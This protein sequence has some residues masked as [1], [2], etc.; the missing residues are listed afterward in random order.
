M[1]AEP[2]AVIALDEL[3]ARMP[4]LNRETGEDGCA[5]EPP[6]PDPMGEGGA[7]CPPTMSG[8]EGAP[9]KNGVGDA[10]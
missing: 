6:P 8:D 4:L 7:W 5:Y 3:I 1:L 2:P 10:C 9:P